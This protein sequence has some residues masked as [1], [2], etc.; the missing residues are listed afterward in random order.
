MDLLDKKALFFKKAENAWLLSLVLSLLIPVFGLLAC[1]FENKTLLTFL[2]LFALLVPIVNQYLKI[3]S[4][5]NFVIGD[6][7]RRLILYADSLKIE[8][9]KDELLAIIPIHLKDEIVK[10]NYLAPYFNSSAT[11]G[12][13]RLVANLSESAFFTGK[14]A[15]FLANIFSL[16]LFISYLFVFGVIYVSSQYLQQNSFGLVIQ[17]GIAA[18]SYFSTSDLLAIRSQFSELG[19]KCLSLFQACKTAENTPNL[20]VESAFQLAEEYHLALSQSPPIPEQVYLWK[21]DS[22]NKAYQDSFGANRP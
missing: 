7:I 9:P 22:L 20:A 12:P 8:P 17:F 15:E 18:I 11:H 19:R 2:G 16:I 3:R 21:R 5:E 14:L 1:W 10:A 4:T 6:K 13:K